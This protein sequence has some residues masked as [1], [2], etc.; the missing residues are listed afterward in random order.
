MA[1]T[2]KAVLVTC[3]DFRI[4]K[5]I[6]DFARENIGEREYDRV[7]WAGAS[8]DFEAVFS[9]IELSKKLHDISEV[10]LMNHE[11][12]GAYGEAGT[13]EK[14]A[15]DLKSAKEKILEKYPNLE[16]KL[17]YIHLDGT[18]DKV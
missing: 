15:E 6:E 1:H 2:C 13:S 18:V 8:K 4:Q 7:C 3:M 11:D 16:V 12:C 10:Y 5:Y 14:H 9:Q 17:L